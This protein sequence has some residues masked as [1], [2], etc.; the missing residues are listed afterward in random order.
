[1]YLYDVTPL[2]LLNFVVI[3]HSVIYMSIWFKLSI[4]LV[5]QLLGKFIKIL[6]YISGAVDVSLKFYPFYVI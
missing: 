2:K 4:M 5:Y 3:R 6:N 1:M